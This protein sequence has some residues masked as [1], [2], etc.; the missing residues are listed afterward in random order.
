MY[1]RRVSDSILDNKLKTFGCVLIV[2][3]KDCGKTTSTKQYSKSVVEFQNEETRDQL[4]Q[5][6]NTYP[7]LLLIG[8]NTSIILMG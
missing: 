6:A 3:P 5:T 2:G 4:I 1:K 8:D 7:S